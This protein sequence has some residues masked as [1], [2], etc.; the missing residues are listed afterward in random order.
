MTIHN[1]FETR[2]RTRKVRRLCKAARE[3]GQRMGE[4]KGIIVNGHI[5]A[6]WLEGAT[7]TDWYKLAEVAR[8]RYPSRF[9]RARV[10]TA[11]RKY[12]RRSA[13]PRQEG[14]LSHAT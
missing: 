6:R 1:S 9:T 11:L 14:G 12:E 3:L 13:R 2:K 10:V 5:L 8:V 7:L 4:E